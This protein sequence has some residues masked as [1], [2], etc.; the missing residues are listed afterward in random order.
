MRPNLNRLLYFTAV[1]EEGT[2]TAAAERLG[3]SK[4]VVSKQIQMLEADIGQS[5]LL[6]NTR[7]VAPTEAGNLLYSSARAPLTAVENAFDQVAERDQTPRGLLRITAPVDFGL[8]FISPLVTRFQEMYPQVQ[9]D[10]LLS[11]ERQDLISERLDLSF[12]IGWLRETGNVARKINTFRE[13]VV[14]APA[15]AAD[16]AISHPK[17]L[18]QIPL[19]LN[20]AVA[21]IAPWRFTQDHN[22]CD[23]L[24]TPVVKMNITMAVL[25]AVQSR[26][27]C[28]IL[29]DIL[30]QDQLA[31]GALV[32]L[33][34]EWS[35]RTGGIYT[36]TPSGQLR[37]NA[38]K[39]FLALV[40]TEIG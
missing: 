16:H 27:Y 15:T 28:T 23:V 7:R 3:V 34:P 37:S 12:Q 20:T 18:T 14:A 13:I 40:R 5:L 22:T 21:E 8:D 35:L 17:D 30:V 24:L 39:A 2:I 11:D 38:L 36:V 31:T 29:P 26:R 19:A 32:Q 25:A 6:R 33:L 4:A 10:L 1:V 9:V